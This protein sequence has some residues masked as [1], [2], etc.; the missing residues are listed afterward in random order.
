MMPHHIPKDSAVKTYLGHILFNVEAANL[1]FYRSLL[2]FMGWQTIED[3]PAMLGVSDGARGSL[4]FGTEGKAIANDYDGRGVN[5]VAL[6]TEAQ[7]DIDAI[8]AYLQEQG[9]ALLFSTPQHRAEFSHGDH[10]YY[11]VMF[12][13]PDGILFECVYT[14]PKAA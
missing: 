1:P 6:G 2:E 8:A 11:Q 4:W 12:E 10:T 14:G 5:H 9:V 3:D 13:S 7:T